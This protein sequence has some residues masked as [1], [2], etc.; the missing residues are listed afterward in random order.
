MNRSELINVLNGFEK[1]YPVE[2]WQYGGIDLWPVIKIDLFFLKFHELNKKD[3]YDRKK[4]SPKRSILFKIKESLRSTILLIKL[5]LSRQQHIP[6]VFSGESNYRVQIDNYFLNR[7]FQPVIDF[8]EENALGSGFIEFDRKIS[9]KN[10]LPEKNFYFLKNYSFASI[11]FIRI[12]GN[13]KKTIPE[14]DAFFKEVSETLNLRQ[15]KQDYLK[16]IHFKIKLI[17]AYAWVYGLLFDKL[18][19]KTVIGLCYYSLPSFGMHYAAHKKGIES[20]DFQHG[21]QGYL[22]IA[23]SMWSKFPEKRIFNVL[24]TTFWC[25]DQVSAN[26]IQSWS[27]ESK[28]KIVVGGNP[29]NHMIDKY[30]KASLNSQDKIILYTMQFEYV[31]N[32]IWD[33]IA[34][35]PLGYKWYLRLHPRKKNFRTELEK[36]LRLRGLTNKVDL[37]QANI[38]PLPV[39]LKKA[40]LHI[41]G[42]S[43]SII[44]GIGFGTCTL[45]TDEIGQEVYSEYIARGVAFYIKDP[46]IQDIFNVLNNEF[47]NDSLLSNNFKKEILKFV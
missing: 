41:S 4:P 8:L 21:G 29:W 18:N 3:T 22:H 5:Y 9:G 38:L 33:A 37:E 17:K 46:S 26:G 20:L 43:G 42:Y 2:K 6:F 15:S 16:H 24:P 1:D 39:L 36:E 7:F 35:T 23:Y 30:S 34:E 25:W 12:F 32:F 31:D 13:F 14:F 27:K 40:S 45:I 10:Y 11:I 47:K 28:H 44:E 19:P